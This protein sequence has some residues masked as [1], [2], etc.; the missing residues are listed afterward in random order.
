V[1]LLLDEHLS[2][3]RIA[4]QLRRRGHDVVALQAATNLW[5]TDDEEVLELATREDRVLV[6]CDAV[7][8]TVLARSWAHDRRTHTGL[9]IVWPRRNDEFRA[10]VDGVSRLLA[11]RPRH[12]DWRDLIVGL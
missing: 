9:I 10:I 2:E 3:R 11:E 5:S 1:R 6:T 12:E 7:G 4:R 8:F